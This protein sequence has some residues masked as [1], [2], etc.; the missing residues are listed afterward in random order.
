MYCHVTLRKMKGKKMKMKKRILTILMVLTMF[1]S[2]VACSGSKD[3]VGSYIMTKMSFGEEEMTAE[4][5][6]SLS[7]MEIE[8]TLEIKEDNSFVLDL[9]FLS[10][11][12]KTSGTWKLDGE[13]LTLS[14]EGDNITTKFDGKTIVMDVDGESLTFE[15][16]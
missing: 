15:K 1:I 16:K 12:D 6:S 13:N 9:G 3:P 11:G 2:L 5:F 4:E 8:I 10:E 7:G 14:A